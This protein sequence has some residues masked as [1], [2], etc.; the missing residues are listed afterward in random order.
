MSAKAIKLAKRYRRQ[1]D[2]VEIYQDI[3]NERY[4]VS[5]FTNPPW[6]IITHENEIQ[7]YT[8]G[9][10]P[11]WIKAKGN[12]ETDRKEAVERANS[13]RKRTYNA[14]A[15]TLFELPSFR[16]PIRHNRCII[17]S[18]GYFEY[19][20]QPDGTTTPYYIYL[21]NEPVFSMAG[22]FDSWLNPQTGKEE[23][24]FSMITTEANDLTG[25]IHNGGKNPHRMPLILPREKEE[26][27]LKPSLSETEIKSFLKTF[28][29][30]DMDAYVVR[31]DFR[32]KNPHDK[33][34]LDKME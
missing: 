8:W 12:R 13:I 19:H 34:I 16:T 25:E 5:A 22:I 18:T 3:L 27:W 17:P 1:S 20:H 10:V 33:T 9:L 26:T 11:F 21:K 4:N 23:Y 30:N 14:R 2:I 29:S 32:K 28:P 7:V 31:P 15:E 24:T 6:P